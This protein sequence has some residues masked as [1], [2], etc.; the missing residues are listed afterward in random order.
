[1]RFMWHSLMARDRETRPFKSWR[2]PDFPFFSF[3]YSFYLI[4]LSSRVAVPP[5]DVQLVGIDQPLSAG[6]E[7]VATCLVR[8]S[9]P[10][11]VLI[12]FLGDDL[13]KEMTAVVVSRFGGLTCDIGSQPGYGK[14]EGAGPLVG[15]TS[16]VSTRVRKYSWRMGY[17]GSVGHSLHRAG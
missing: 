8:G 10:P 14:F 13:I 15:D 2:R 4:F 3:F 17:I 5:L 16:L 11:P 12:W 6:K 7:A 9:R 1:M